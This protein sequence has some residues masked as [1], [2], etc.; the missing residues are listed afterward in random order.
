MTAG[1]VHPTI[2][3]C[4]PN[5]TATDVADWPNSTSAGPVAPIPDVVPTPVTVVGPVEFSVTVRA[6]LFTDSGATFT[7]PAVPV[8][9]TTCVPQFISPLNAAE[10]ANS[11]L[12]AVAFTV[13]VG[14]HDCEP[15]RAQFSDNDA[16][17]DESARS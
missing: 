13:N 17:N 2:T 15:S 1:I 16:C 14:A 10:P 4:V 12:V 8:R 9:E 3:V 6:V 5:G 11:E 7:V